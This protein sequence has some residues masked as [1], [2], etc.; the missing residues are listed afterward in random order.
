MRPDRRE[1]ELHRGSGEVTQTLPD[2]TTARESPLVRGRMILDV[3]TP[4]ENAKGALP[5]AINIPVDELRSRLG[6]LDRSKPIAI[7]CQVGMRGWIAQSILRQS[8][9]TDVVNIKGG[10][11]LAGMMTKS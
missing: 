3:R 2:S 1:Q 7:L 11:T 9:F 6:E 5:G 4:E 10:Y 8:G